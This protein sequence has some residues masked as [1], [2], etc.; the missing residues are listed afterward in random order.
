MLACDECAH[1]SSADYRLRPT[2]GLIDHL[3]HS[4]ER[5]FSATSEKSMSIYKGR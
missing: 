3:I 5:C 4:Q 1:E 2:L